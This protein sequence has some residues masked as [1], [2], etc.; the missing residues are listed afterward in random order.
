MSLNNKNEYLSEFDWYRSRSINAP[1]DSMLN[2]KIACNEVLRHHISVPA[3]DFVKN[4]GR[5]VSLN[6]VS[7]SVKTEAVLVALR[8]S[9]TYFLK[10][11]AAGKGIGVHRLDYEDGRY[12]LDRKLVEERS[13]L[14]LLESS[15]GWLLTHGIQQHPI[16][17]ELHAETT[18]TLRMI[19]IR[20]TDGLAELLFSVL[21]LGTSKTV[22]VDN[23][24]RGGLVAHVDLET[25]VLSQ[26]RTLWSNEEFDTHPDS[27]VKIRSIS[28]PNWQQTCES[29]LD[30]A[31]SLPYLQFVAWDVLLTK[32]GPVVIEANT[33]SGVNIIQVWG[34]QRD[35][36]LGNFYRQHGVIS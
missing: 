9:K 23:G 25:G 35:G 22:P 36:K 7:K 14:D 34:P 3:I 28:L 2:N 33:S 16:L 18:N 19:T 12:V 29:I 4:K 27:G 24:S 15:D 20:N 5:L 21:R 30:L 1:F 13:I 31:D 17:A 10:P 11:L 6:D 8:D 32:D 26:A